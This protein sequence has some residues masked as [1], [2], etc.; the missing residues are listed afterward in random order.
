MTS[1]LLH[2]KNK[3]G[4][5]IGDWL[6]KALYNRSTHTLVEEEE[7][8]YHTTRRP[9]LRN[10]LHSSNSRSGLLNL[11]RDTTLPF[12]KKPLPYA[13]DGILG[14]NHGGYTS[15][16]EDTPLLSRRQKRSSKSNN[17]NSSSKKTWQVLFM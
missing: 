1:S 10:N 8:M 16:D 12:S 17:N 3:A 2:D 13:K 6:R 5:G 9:R 7:D 14:A 15:D 11:W 4:R